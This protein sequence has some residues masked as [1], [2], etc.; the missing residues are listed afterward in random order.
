MTIAKAC[1][2]CPRGLMSGYYTIYLDRYCRW[3]CFTNE[4]GCPSSFEREVIDIP[5]VID[6]IKLI[7]EK[8]PDARIFLDAPNFLDVPDRRLLP[9]ESWDQHIQVLEEIVKA[10]VKP[11][12][13][14]ETTVHSMLKIS[15]YIFNLLSQS[16]VQ[17]IW[18][19]VESALRKLRNLY[20]KPPFQNRSLIQITRKL[21]SKGILCGWYLVVGYLDTDKS[22]QITENLI[23]E[24][25]PDRIFPIQAIPYDSNQQFISL[26]KLASRIPKIE[27]F[28]AR[29]Q[30][31]AQELDEKICN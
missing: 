4:G 17:E 20:Y 12:L 27:R 26:G 31:I 30:R 14:I 28:Q 15:D 6:R 24:A 21:Q 16:G 10:R 11:Y 3:Q 25:E 1:Y 19:G 2:S 23:R 29:L 22:I 8:K 18:M 9:G 13:R 5:G 7:L